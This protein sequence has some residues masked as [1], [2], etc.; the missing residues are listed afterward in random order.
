MTG[1]EELTS[2]DIFEAISHPLRIR[3]L[4]VLA[5]RSMRFAELKRGLK[6]K[7]SGRLDFHLTKLGGLIVT[8]KQGS[9]DVTKYGIMA[10]TAINT[11]QKCRSWQRKAYY[12]TLATLLIAGV[13]LASTNNTTLLLI[14]FL[15]TTLWMSYLPS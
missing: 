10:L 3:I 7:S 9:Y 2:N 8:N 1:R 13:F 15:G 5:K 14:M 11:V 6:I 4:R 12:I